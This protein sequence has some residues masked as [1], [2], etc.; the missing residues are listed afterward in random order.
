MA[1]K[2]GATALSEAE[3]IHELGKRLPGIPAATIKAV[4]KGFKEEVTECLSQGYKI[5]L[6]GLL[7]IT[8]GSK[9]GRKKGTVV[10]N[11]FDGTSKT[12]RAD[13]PDKFFVKAKASTLT[14]LKSFPTVKSAKGQEL[15]KSLAPAKKKAA[16]SKGK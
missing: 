10:R 3:L 5:T 8:P 7:T 16:A 14:I 12:L 13:E 6:S 4:V 2:S 9:P 11:P 15:L 1:S